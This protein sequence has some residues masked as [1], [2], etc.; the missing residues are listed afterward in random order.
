M[1]KRIP[2]QKETYWASIVCQ[3]ANGKC[4]S[5]ARG[6]IWNSNVAFCNKTTCLLKPRCFNRHLVTQLLLLLQELIRKSL[7]TFCANCLSVIIVYWESQ[8][9]WNRTY[10]LI[11]F[12]LLGNSDLLVSN[13]VIHSLKVTP[14]VFFSTQFS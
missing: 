6:N 1:E 10:L 9:H 4:F 13:I 11:A 3:R 12:R 2:W 14:L 7:K 8:I 5:S